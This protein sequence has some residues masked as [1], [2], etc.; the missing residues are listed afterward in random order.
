MF[1]F[2][3]VTAALIYSKTLYFGK[4]TSLQYVFTIVEIIL[5]N[6]VLLNIIYGHLKSKIMAHIVII[7]LYNIIYSA[8]VISY[9]NNNISVN[10]TLNDMSLSII[11]LNI[12]IPCA[13]LGEQLEENAIKNALQNAENSRLHN[14]SN[15]IV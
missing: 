14:T 2:N 11:I 4:I 13:L 3:I 6:I 9:Y 5:I 10:D 1:I 12:I 7:S 8:T 15:E